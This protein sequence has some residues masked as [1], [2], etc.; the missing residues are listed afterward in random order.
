M[1]HWQKWVFASVLCIWRTST[2]PSLLHS[3][4]HW[5]LADDSLD[6]SHSK[7]RRFA[8]PCSPCIHYRWHWVRP[9]RCHAVW[10]Y[11][12]KQPLSINKHPHCVSATVPWLK[13]GRAP[14]TAIT[15]RG[16]HTHTHTKC[17]INNIK[18]TKKKRRP[19][20]ERSGTNEPLGRNKQSMGS[21][22]PP[23]MGAELLIEVHHN[24]TAAHRNINIPIKWLLLVNARLHCDSPLKVNLKKEKMGF[25]TGL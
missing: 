17:R 20:R 23:W 19:V 15:A 6:I 2:L 5:V 1:C 22:F 12:S 16:T 4:S 13:S 18:L 11:Y 24:F 8:C 10:G 9:S 14:S 25:V 7:Y 21:L 3:A